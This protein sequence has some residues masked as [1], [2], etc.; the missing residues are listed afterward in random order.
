MKV[1]TV[2]SAYAVLMTL[3]ALVWLVAPAF[4]LTLFGVREST[5]LTVV[6]GRFVGALALGP[7]IIAWY[8]RD[9][10]QSARSGILVGLATSSAIAAAVSLHAALP[11]R[12]SPAAWG[13]MIGFGA[14]AVLFG[15]ALLPKAEDQPAVAI[16]G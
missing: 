6:L 12:I 7:A 13:V 9:A 1:R 14:F 11:G 3:G 5:F 10:T 16:D 4:Y 15:S 2:L 8:A